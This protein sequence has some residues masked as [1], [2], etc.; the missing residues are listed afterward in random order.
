MHS[1]SAS[2]LLALLATSAQLT[3]A[4]TPAPK[5]RPTAL[6]FIDDD[7]RRALAQAKT[8]HV[9]IFVEAWAPW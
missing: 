6:P 3:F 1:S 8:R 5:S 4:S 2:W 9:P 7:Y